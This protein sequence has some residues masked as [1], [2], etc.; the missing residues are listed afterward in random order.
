MVKLIWRIHTLSAHLLHLHL[1]CEG[2]L[3]SN[4]LN[5]P[6]SI[7]SLIKSRWKRMCYTQHLDKLDIGYNRTGICLI[8]TNTS[9]CRRPK[10]VKWLCLWIVMRFIPHFAWS[11][12]CPREQCHTKSQAGAL[13]P[14]TP[15]SLHWTSRLQMQFSKVKFI[16]DTCSMNTLFSYRSTSILMLPLNQFYIHSSFSVEILLGRNWQWANPKIKGTNMLM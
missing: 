12:G 6:R 7:T 15:S 11:K 16:R 8:V 5:V 1:R 4:N 3:S 9:W 2:I 14:H 13:G 10:Q